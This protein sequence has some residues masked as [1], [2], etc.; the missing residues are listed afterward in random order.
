LQIL[1]SSVRL[2]NFIDF[3]VRTLPKFSKQLF[4]GYIILFII[5]QILTACL[6]FKVSQKEIEKK[7]MGYQ[8][9]P[10]QHQIEVQGLNMNYAEIGTDS[11][12]VAFFKPAHPSSW[13]GFIDFTR[14]TKFLKK[15]KM[16]TVD[17][18]GFGESNFGKGEN[19]LVLPAELLKPIVAK[20]KN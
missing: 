14:V 4:L 8:L 12:P 2:C 18:I 17:R 6:T 19:S 20:Y 7:F 11:W 1:V 3:Q 13:G 16:M 10:H 15:V 9:K 5:Y